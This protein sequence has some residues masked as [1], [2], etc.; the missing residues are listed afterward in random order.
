MSSLL[1]LTSTIVHRPSSG[2]GAASGR[3]SA[4]VVWTHGLGDTP[5]GWAMLTQSFARAMPHAI[6]VHPAAPN[7]PVSCNMGAV[8][9]SWMDLL[10]IPVTPGMED[11]GRDL[12]ESVAMMHAT[13]DDIVASENIPAD[14]IVL[15][16][17]S[18]GGALSLV[19][20]LKYPKKLAGTVVLS[21]WCPPK[22][23]VNALVAASPTKDGKFFIGHGDADGV[24]VPSCGEEVVKVLKQNGVAV[25]SEVYPNM[26][27]SSCGKEEKD[28]L[29]FLKEV[30]P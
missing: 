18:Q 2:A 5:H 19:S 3:P 20:A 14:R 11:N 27:H 13:V 16:G 17:F 28:V 30:I 25:T 10:N 12:D 26:A 21:G 7:L 15:A 8:M 9:P 24:V 6:F 23:D 4:A 1:K 22:A 29:E